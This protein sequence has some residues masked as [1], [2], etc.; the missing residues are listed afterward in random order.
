MKQ[1][2][3][4]ERVRKLLAMSRDTASPHEAAIAARRAR[5]LMDEYQ[6][7]ELDLTTV[8]ASDMGSETLNTKTK[9]VV[10]PIDALS[11]ACAK[12]NDCKARLTRINGF[13][14]YT[15]EG[16]LADAV[17][18]GEMLK[19]LR[20]E[21]YRQAEAKA[22]GRA[23]R[24]AYRLGFAAGVQEQVKEILKEREQLK[25]KQSGTSL[26]VIK[27]ALV[28]QHFGAAKYRRKSSSFQGDSDA[29]K[30]GMRAGK[31]VNLSRQVSEQPQTRIS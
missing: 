2:K 1:D 5:A 17:C 3:V 16:M 25:T 29:F 19:Y 27:Q 11:V 12:L 13:V 6:I 8:S 23:D 26:M 14:S 22:V 20:N 9:Q 7:S 31:H 30:Q 4:L 15:F 21:M 28:E 10:M 18:A 24:H